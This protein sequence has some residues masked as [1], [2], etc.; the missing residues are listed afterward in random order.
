MA[1]AVATSPQRARQL[2]GDAADME[3]NQA[4]RA[5]DAYKSRNEK[6]CR[7]YLKNRGRRDNTK[8]GQHKYGPQRRARYHHNVRSLWRKCIRAGRVFGPEDLF[9]QRPPGGKKPL[10][11]YNIK[12]QFDWPY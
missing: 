2:V 3:D 10:G 8:S 7:F 1:A 12:L 9:S 4:A 11:T 5:Q 6:R